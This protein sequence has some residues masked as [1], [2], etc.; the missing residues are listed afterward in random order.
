[1]TDVTAQEILE[2]IRHAIGVYRSLDIIG[3]FLGCDA[4]QR[5]DRLSSPEFGAELRARVE[6]TDIVR[7][8]HFAD[9][10]GFCHEC[11][12]MSPCP[13]IQALTSDRYLRGESG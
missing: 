8:L 11:L 9:S 3:D 12:Y 2:Q 6:G 10:R 7:E 4:H 5:Y 1:M 13:T